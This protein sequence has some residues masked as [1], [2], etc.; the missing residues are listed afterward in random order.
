MLCYKIVYV[1]TG[2]NTAKAATIAIAL[3]TSTTA[4]SWKIKVRMLECDSMSLAP[5]GCLQY[6][7]GV[8]GKFTSFN[9]PTSR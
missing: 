2:R 7:T 1:D 9:N 8:G 4:R 6:F 3:A 5:S